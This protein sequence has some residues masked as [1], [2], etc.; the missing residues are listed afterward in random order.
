MEKN[1]EKRIKDWEKMQKIE[2]MEK[3]RRKGENI[4]EK[5]ITKKNGRK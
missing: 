4:K 1:G 2:K 3:N 5:E